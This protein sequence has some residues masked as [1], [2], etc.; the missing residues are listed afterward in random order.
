VAAYLEQAKG[1]AR[2]CWAP[3]LG[4]LQKD[5]SLAS[6]LPGLEGGGKC[7]LGMK[8]QSLMKLRKLP[9]WQVVAQTCL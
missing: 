7:F 4:M 6:S 1:A 9:S 8:A 3:L 5:R 2:L